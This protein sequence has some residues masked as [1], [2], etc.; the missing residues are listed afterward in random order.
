MSKGILDSLNTKEKL[1]TLLYN[2]EPAHQKKPT[3]C[4]ECTKK[5]VFSSSTFL[6]ITVSSWAIF[7]QKRSGPLYYNFIFSI[8]G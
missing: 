6:L 4:W 7:R 1:K 5:N 3:M 8:K 2:N